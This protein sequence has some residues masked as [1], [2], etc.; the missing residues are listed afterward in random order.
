M[1]LVLLLCL[2]CKEDVI[3]D[4]PDASLSIAEEGQ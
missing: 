4:E 2:T 3:A 1:L